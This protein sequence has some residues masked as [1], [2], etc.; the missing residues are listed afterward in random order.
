MSSCCE[1]HEP[2]EPN[3]ASSAPTSSPRLQLA[4]E[5]LA[6]EEEILARPRQASQASTEAELDPGL[7]EPAAELPRPEVGAETSS[8][9]VQRWLQWGAERLGAVDVVHQDRPSLAKVW[10]YAR[11]SEQLPPSGPARWFS[12]G[13]AGLSL[14]ITAIAYTTAWVAERPA[15]MGVAAV[16]VTVFVIWLG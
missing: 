3:S 9:P 2:N 1:A 14:L 5:P 11:F 15:R 7:A 8:A 12:I 13:Y 10:R 4:P 6:D 16:L